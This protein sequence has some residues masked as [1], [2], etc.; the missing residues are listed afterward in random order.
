GNT[1]PSQTGRDIV[2]VVI[3][4]KKG[5]EIKWT[6]VLEVFCVSRLIEKPTETK[7]AIIIECSYRTNTRTMGGGTM[8]VVHLANDRSSTLYPYP[9]KPWHMSYTRELTLETLGGV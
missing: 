6:E 5:S 4:A 9:Y 3:E 8:L 2:V 1:T 7:L